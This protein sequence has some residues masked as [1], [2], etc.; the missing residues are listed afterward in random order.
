MFRSEEWKMSRSSD[1]VL[2]CKSISLSYSKSL[3]HLCLF[4]NILSAYFCPKIGLHIVTYFFEGRTSGN[5]LY[6]DTSN[7]IR[8]L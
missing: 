7:T 8:C 6:S 1:T 5:N 2:I 3:V 4:K